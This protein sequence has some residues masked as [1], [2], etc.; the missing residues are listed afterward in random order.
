MIEQRVIELPVH[1]VSGTAKAEDH[2]ALAV[3]E[4]LEIRLG[5]RVAGVWAQR[6]VTVTMRTPG[7]DPELAA[8][9]LFTEGVVRGPEDIRDIRHCG[10][11]A[12]PLQLQNV[13]QVNLAAHAEVE[14]VRL[15]RNFLSNSS[16]GV[17]GKASL[18]A[19]ARL[20]GARLP[21]GFTIPAAVIHAMPQ[22]LREAQAVFERTG[23][24]H[25]AAL[26]DAEG[27]LHVLR[28]DVGRHNAVDKLIGRQLLDHRVPVSDRL[29]FVSGRAGYELVQK[30]LAAGIP[31]LAAVGAPSSLAADLARAFNM[32]LLGFVRND[33]FNVYSG[34][35]RV[36]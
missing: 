27:R 35:D 30:A 33:R 2:D 8:G 11:A 17:C 29:L 3:E 14:G 25:A 13:V 31:M 10:P 9:F 12:G 7:N 1:R 15:E 19:L 34:N 21:D 20:P 28:E 18:E 36:A 6:S 16:C 22:R 26:F 5:C 23:G 24:L 32:G 4:A